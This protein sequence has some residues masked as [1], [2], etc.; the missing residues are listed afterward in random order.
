MSSHDEMA[1]AH[2]KHI[3]TMCI[4]AEV[5]E[6]TIVISWLVIENKGS[7]CYATSVAFPTNVDQSIIAKVVQATQKAGD[8]AHQKGIKIP[9][10]TLK[11]PHTHAI[12]IKHKSSHDFILA[13]KELQRFIET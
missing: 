5:F 11:N 7:I 1:Y 6:Q 9:D 4:D 3:L 8:L 2:L 12:E 13:Q 10:G